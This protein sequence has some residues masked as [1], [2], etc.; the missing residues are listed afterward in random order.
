MKIHIS[1]KFQKGPWGGGNQ[2]LKA[3]KKEF[4][5]ME[6]CT[7]DPE[8]AEIILFNSHH[9]L[10]KVFEVKKKFPQK[11]FVHRINGPV[12]LIRGKDKALDRII[13]QFNNLVADGIVFQ[14]NWC[15]EQNKKLFNVLSNYETVIYNAPDNHVF[16]R[17]NK[18]EFN[19]KEKIKLITTNWSSNWRKGFRVYKFLDEN[20]DFSK[21]EITFVG[22][23]PIKFENIKLI[24]PVNSEILAKILKGN[25]IYITVIDEIEGVVKNYK[26]YRSQIP[27]FSIKKV[28]KDYYDFAEK[29]FNDVQRGQHQLKQVN[30]LTKINFYKMKSMILKWRGLNKIRSIKGKL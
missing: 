18:K 14:S 6:V 25:D 7:E 27:E 26:D 9:C 20:L 3:L 2:F 11:I 19:P 4:E 23:S 8:K 1:Y 28:A 22:Y 29:I 15:R 17:N 12:Q 16:N 5:E 24:K 30:L 10:D 21:Y 13:Y